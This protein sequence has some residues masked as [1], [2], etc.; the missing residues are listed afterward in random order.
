[1]NTKMLTS[2]QIEQLKE[3]A[4]VL[5]EDKQLPK[6][7]IVV[8]GVTGAGKSTLINAVFDCELTKTGVGRP[9]TTEI[10][11][12]EENDIPIRIWDTMG[13]ELSDKQVRDTINAIKDVIA[14]KNES[15][16]PFDRIHAIW[17]CIQ[18][19]GSKFQETESNFIKELSGLGVPF[20]IV[21]TKCISKSAD[22]KFED[23]VKEILKNDGCDD[24]PIV[25][26][27]AQDWEI[28]EGL[29]ITSKGLENLVDVTTE[30]LENYVYASFISAQTISKILKRELAEG[31]ILSECD[32]L[33]RKWYEAYIPI[34][35]IFAANTRMERMFKTIGQVYNTNLSETEIKSIYDNSIGEWKGKAANLINPFGHW[36]FK[37]A[38]DFF[39]VYIKGQK[40]F[41]RSDRNIEEY[42]WAAKLILWSG[43]SWILAI[44]EHWDEL[45]KADACSRNEIVKQ[46]INRLKEYM[47]GKNREK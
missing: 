44:E 25:R 38:D 20:I 5:M 16:D 4:A 7:N 18:S 3:R 11:S 15:N 42:E 34:A 28:D 14:E 46:M 1:M 12:W 10:K 43:Y 17:Y 27:L 30:N 31:H 29:V 33:R 40:G 36:A 45:I 37:K 32:E 24:I 47:S 21:L 13:L 6:A 26:V 22:D 8:A 19:T 39:N 9:I 41:D 35:N 2:N 23:A